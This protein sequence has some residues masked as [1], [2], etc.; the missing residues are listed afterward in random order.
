MPNPQNMANLAESDQFDEQEKKEL[1]KIMNK[2]FELT[3]RNTLIGLKKDKKQEAKFIDDGVEFW[4]S[5]FKIKLQ[6]IMKKINNYWKEKSK[7][8]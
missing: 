8:K 6:E 2:S 3:S 4:K 1:I 5:E 7:Q